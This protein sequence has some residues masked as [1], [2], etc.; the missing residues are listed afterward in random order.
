MRDIPAND[1]VAGG[2]KVSNLR[3]IV[4]KD[5]KAKGLVCH[6]IRCREVKGNYNPREK[7]Y[8]FRQD[9][10]ASQGKE[11]FLSFE[12]KT[13]TKLYSLLR[14]R[15]PS[16]Y[17]F[18]EL[19]NSS[20]IRE[21]HT[22]GQLVPISKQKIAPQHKG[23]GKKLIEEAEKITREEFNLPK[24]SVISGVGVRNYYRKLGYKL[25]G[26][27]G[28][29]IKKFKVQNS[30]SKQSSNSKVQRPGLGSQRPG[31]N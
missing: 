25:V 23:L 31:L 6:C 26:E 17:I 22:Y 3:E 24:I 5:M 9:Y 10:K 16:S 19:K 29:M 1:I 13:R 12:N 15:K 2:A 11:I 27:Y 14:L 21:V 8:L 18:K 7:I 4:Q 28:Y 20:I 30:K